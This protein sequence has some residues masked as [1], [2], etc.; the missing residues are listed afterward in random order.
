MPKDYQKK[1]NMSVPASHGYGTAGIRE[2]FSTLYQNKCINQYGRN[3]LII[4][5]YN[6]KEG[7]REL[8]SDPRLISLGVT[9][10][11]G[12]SMQM[13]L[14]STGSGDRGAPTQ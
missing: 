9:A 8:D 13:P 14:N 3:E 5:I 6:R 4:D 11:A 2:G 1:K 12:E 10:L 7:E